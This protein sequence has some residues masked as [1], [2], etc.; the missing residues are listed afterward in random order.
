MDCK[1]SLRSELEVFRI[2]RCHYCI[3]II[4]RWA[5]QFGQRYIILEY[6]VQ[7][8]NRSGFT[9]GNCQSVIDARLLQLSGD[10]TNKVFLSEEFL[11]NGE[12]IVC[13]TNLLPV[14]EQRIWVDFFCKIAE[15]KVNYIAGYFKN[16]SS[17]LT[18][19]IL[20]QHLSVMRAPRGRS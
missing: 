16:Q 10:A 14:E 3:S 2:H 1:L 11:L 18:V 4:Q 7:D 20:T 19:I 8:L 17:L 6:F 12:I 13:K 5:V 9:Q 15:E